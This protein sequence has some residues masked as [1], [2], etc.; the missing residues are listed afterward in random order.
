M[1]DQIRDLV[2]EIYDTVA[3]PALWPGALDKFS[4]M[5][6]ARGCIVF[7][8]RGEGADRRIAAPIYTSGYE[9]ELVEGYIHAFQ[10][11]EMADQDR[12]EACSLAADGIDLIDDSV[13]T[14]SEDE[15]LAQAN[16]KQLLEYGIR[17][18]AAGLLDK[19]NRAR[20]RFSVQHSLR[21]GPMRE[22]ER[23]IAAAV[24][25]HIAKALDLGRPAAQ[26]SGAYKR[27]I[28]A[29]DRLRIAVCILDRRGRVVV[30]NEE[31]D[32]QRETY[33]A[34]R[35]DRSG[36]LHLHDGADGERFKALLA[37]ALN[38]GRHGAR[39]RKEAIATRQGDN[40]SALCIEIAPL[41]TAEEIGSTALGG[42]ILY[43]LD[44]SL[45]M[46]CD[47]SA[48]RRIFGLTGAEAALVQLV[49]DGLTNAQIAEHRERSVETVNAQVKSVLNKTQCANRTQLVRLM[50]NFGADFL[51]PAPEGGA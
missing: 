4:E 11:Q 51:R 47:P 40:V 8:M 43:S 12:F 41:D 45:P 3:D 21:H 35:I 30:T 2:L 13:L 49:G 42:A 29:M 9:A 33:D 31:F 46:T 32:R 38:H 26:L 24:L 20:S 22:E 27:L 28:A 18:R 50:A 17:H 14:D 36:R 6:G 5:I 25:P 48:L 44:T 15:L 39:P 23:E 19:D 34:F 1:S 7:E 16:V 37:D 10:A